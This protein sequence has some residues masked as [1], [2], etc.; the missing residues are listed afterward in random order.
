MIC[1]SFLSQHERKKITTILRQHSTYE[2][3]EDYFKPMSKET[4]LATDPLKSPHQTILTTILAEHQRLA[5]S[6]PIQQ[7]HFL[8]LVAAGLSHEPMVPQKEMTILLDQVCSSIGC[9]MVNP[10][11]LEFASH[12]KYL[13][14][15]HVVPYNFYASESLLLNCL[16]NLKSIFIQKAENTIKRFDIYPQKAPLLLAGQSSKNDFVI[17]QYHYPDVPNV[18]YAPHWPSEQLSHLLTQQ[19]TPLETLLCLIE[20]S[21]RFDWEI[22][23]WKA[24]S[25]HPEFECLYKAIIRKVLLGQTIHKS[26]CKQGTPLIGYTDLDI[27]IR[28]GPTR[29]LLKRMATQ[30]VLFHYGQEAL[31]SSLYTIHRTI[32]SDL[33][34]AEAGI[35]LSLYPAMFNRY[36]TVSKDKLSMRRDLLALTLNHTLS[37]LDERILLELFTHSHATWAWKTLAPQLLTV[38]VSQS[39]VIDRSAHRHPGFWRLLLQK[40]S[41]TLMESLCQ[42]H[43][44][45]QDIIDRM[46][47]EKRALEESGEELPPA[48]RLKL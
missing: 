29:L 34:C 42:K 44:A 17:P 41:P 18:Y 26:R 35:F 32:D 8:K 5:N 36:K 14:R 10:H 16:P 4:L 48:K 2:H 13:E 22:N 46:N 30:G 43:P 40:L 25:E 1:L 9:G 20:R 27:M 11:I 39:K 33:E 12:F 3:I 28:S 7:Q 47:R 31:F 37:R 15:I 6:Y 23:T 24:L 38:N 19:S 21:D 45:L